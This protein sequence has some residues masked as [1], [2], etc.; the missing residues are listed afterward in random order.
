LIIYSVEIEEPPTSVP[1]TDVLSIT[2]NDGDYAIAREGTG[3]NVYLNDLYWVGQYLGGGHDVNQTFLGFDIASAIPFEN[4]ITSAK[5]VLTVNEAY[6][7][8]VAEVRAHAWTSDGVTAFVPGSQLASKPLLGSTTISAGNSGEIVIDLTVVDRATERI[9]LSAAAQRLGV[10]TT[11]D[12]TFRVTNARLELG[13]RLSSAPV[14]R[15]PR[16]FHWL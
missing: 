14:V 16:W 13:H 9:V 11:D 2:A 1:A 8:A 5:L 4:E 15:Q 3:T 10:P 6:G 7:L 12:D